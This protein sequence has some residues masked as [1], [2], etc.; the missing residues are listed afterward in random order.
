MEWAV[1]LNYSDDNPRSRIWPILSPQQDLV[2]HTPALPHRD[3]VATVDT[4]RTS[5]AAPAV[6]LPFEFLVRGKG[7]RGGRGATHRKPA[8]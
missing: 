8:D 4:V 3:L 6:K 7:G 2:R 5:G 1:A